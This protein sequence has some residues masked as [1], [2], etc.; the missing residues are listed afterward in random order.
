[1]RVERSCVRRLA[2]AAALFAVAATGLAAGP[3]PWALSEEGRRALD[4]VS[5]D[6]LRGHLSFLASDA[7]G[8]RVTPSAGQDIAAEYIAAQFR[9]AAL[10]PLGDD[11]YFQDAPAVV[12]TPR[13]EGFRL[14]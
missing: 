5:A 9:R 13:A 2:S 3:G 11:G 7:L 8:G 6:S 14:A 1:M 4:L 10:E 12:A